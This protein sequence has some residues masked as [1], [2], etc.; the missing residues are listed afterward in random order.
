MTSIIPLSDRVVIRAKKQE[1]TTASGFVLSTAESKERPQSGE[2]L[3]VGPDVKNVSV[4][5]VVI[6]K[7]YIPTNFSHNNEEFLILKEEDILAKIS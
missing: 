1:E 4:G 2:V 3:S 7:E 6:F 5:D